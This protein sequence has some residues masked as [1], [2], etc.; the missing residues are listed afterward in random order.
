MEY[1]IRRWVTDLAIYIGSLNQTLRS[2][3][4]VSEEVTRRKD[5]VDDLKNDLN[6]IEQKFN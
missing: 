5:L 4:L 3:E 6:T 1:N 2:C